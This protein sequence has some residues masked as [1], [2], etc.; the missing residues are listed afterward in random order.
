VTG[1]LQ[2]LCSRTQ[3]DVY[4]ST[5]DRFSADLTT[6]PGLTLITHHTRAGLL[7]NVSFSLSKP[8]H[9]G[10]VVIRGSDTVFSTSADFSGGTGLFAIGTPTA[11]GDLMVRLAATDLAGNFNRI[12]G[13]LTVDP[14][15][16]P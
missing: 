4:C 12:E 11:A 15:G 13:T 7:T 8:A 1:F 3:T 2:S 5:A 9:V 16:G 10:I 14:G 6:P